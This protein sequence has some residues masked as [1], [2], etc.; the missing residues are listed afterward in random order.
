METDE[1]KISKKI[2][3][4]FIGQG[5]KLSV[6]ESCT[7]GLI[8]HIITSVSGASIFFDSSIVCYSPESK[9]KLLGVKKSIIKAHGTISEEA[10]IAMAKGAEAKTASDVGLA[11]TGNLGPEPIEGKQ[12]GLVYIAVSS[13]GSFTSKGFL[14]EGGREEIKHAAALAALEFLREAVSAW[15]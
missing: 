12:S 15:T 1:L 5:L 7:G 10:A 9:H 6:A 2:H 4:L 13:G 14:F 8:G 11:V 3:R